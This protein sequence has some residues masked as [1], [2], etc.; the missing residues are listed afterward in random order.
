MRVI[1]HIDG[2]KP[3]IS[4]LRDRFP[5]VEFVS[6][7]TDE[8]LAAGLAAAEALLING[9]D[10]SAAVS[11]AAHASRTLKWIQFTSSG[12][13]GVLRNGGYPAHVVATNVAGLRAGN[14]SEHAFG[15]L[16]FL[17][18]Q[19][20]AVESARQA[21]QFLK[22]ELFPG[23]VSLKGRTMLI[24]GLGAIGQ[25]TARKA[26]GFG[27]RVLGISRAYQP[28][29]LIDRIYPREDCDDAFRQADVLMVAAP[30]DGQ[31]RGFVDARRLGL[32]KKT[33]IVLNVSR[34]DVIEE[35]AL[36]EACREGRIA[37][38]GL[39]VMEIEPLP[40][41]SPLWTLENVIV[42]PHVGGAGSDQRNQLLDRMAE[43]IERYL[44][45]EKLENIVTA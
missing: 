8:E 34:G 6:T 7:S 25:D 36:I 15:M 20:R 24:L 5:S 32:M 44:K 9:A 13:D 17:T 22:Q 11:K 29:A 1:Y 35:A 40:P 28:D 27:M 26:K 45:G 12:I 31:T 37:G 4:R 30:S 21:K 10:F 14:L 38:A 19:L 39:D 2:R 3:D 33:A 16:L 42:T 43:N 23:M 41:E 18:R